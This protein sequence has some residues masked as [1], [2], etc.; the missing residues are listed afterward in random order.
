MPRQR[1]LS[2]PFVLWEPQQRLMRQLLRRVTGPPLTMR[3]RRQP[4]QG[5]HQGACWQP[6]RRRAR[7]SMP[8]LRAPSGLR[9]PPP[10][11][12]PPTP[13]LPARR[14]LPAARSGGRGERRSSS[15]GMMPCRSWPPLRSRWRQ[16][17][18][19][20]WPIVTSRSP[21][22]PWRWRWAAWPAAS[23]AEAPRAASG[24]ASE[25]AGRTIL[26]SWRSWSCR[27][28]SA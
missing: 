4:R 27:M 6:L 28:G 18:P 9:R 19:S 23:R 20:C 26:P 10:L 25:P 16:R 5:E 15:G 14:P 17:C 3:R 24:P 13:C 22:L 2:I 1:L 21:P 11:S 7:P 12:P 8:L